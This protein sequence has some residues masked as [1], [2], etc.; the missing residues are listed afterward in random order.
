[1][2]EIAKDY[3]NA[4]TTLPFL[5]TSQKFNSLHTQK[6]MSSV[7]LSDWSSGPAMLFKKI[8]FHATI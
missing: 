1:M 4:S 7:S 6:P 2:L 5:N 8:F 3:G